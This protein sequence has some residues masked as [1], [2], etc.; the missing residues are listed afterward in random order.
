VVLGKSA[1]P[2]IVAFMLPATEPTTA[3]PAKAETDAAIATR[4]TSRDTRA[5]LFSLNMFLTPFW[6]GPAISAPGL[7]IDKCA[8]PL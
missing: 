6:V 5:F 4:S 2:P 3:D 7:P 1:C 8:D